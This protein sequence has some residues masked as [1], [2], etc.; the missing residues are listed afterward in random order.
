MKTKNKF[1]KAIPATVVILSLATIVNS[2]NFIDKIFGKADDLTEKVTSTLDNAIGTLNAN[3]ANFQEILQKLAADLPAEVQ[4]TITNE[5]TNLLNR[6]VAAAGAEVRC[7]ADF[8]RIRVQQ[9]LIR[10]KAKFLNQTVPPLE[11]QLCN[12]VPLAIDMGLPANRRNKLE[13]YGYDFDATAIQVILVNG[14]N[15][16]NVTD[17][18]DQPTHYHMTLNLGSNGVPLG[19]NSTRLVLRWNN[20]DISSIGIIQKAPD[21]CE[22]SFFQFQPAT[23]SYMPP[24]TKGD[25]E[26]KDHGPNMHA[27]VS[28]INNGNNVV[29]RVYLKAIETKSDWTTAEG[30]KNFVIY[31]ADPGKRIEAIVTATSSSYS[32]IDDNHN[33]DEFPGTG[34]VR[35]FKFMGDGEGDDVGHHTRVEIDFTNI[36]VQLKETSDCVSSTTLR[37]LEMQNAISPALMQKVKTIKTMKFVTPMEVDKE[38]K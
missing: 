24:H 4:S 20:R 31:T 22:T 3:S 28:L 36:R 6:T 19:T 30:S 35:K 32:Y 14:T 23:I 38:N 8:F 7:D 17:K 37:I 15:E 29:A 11:P 34:P 33:M 12:V 1:V 18:L 26:F 27:S 5:V 9:A 13:F 25:R 16:I 21:I 10:I 2:C